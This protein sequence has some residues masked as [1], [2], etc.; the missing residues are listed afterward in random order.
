MRKIYIDTNISQI[1]GYLSGKF[2]DLLVSKLQEASILVLSNNSSDVDEIKNLINQIAGDLSKELVLLVNDSQSELAKFAKDKGFNNIFTNPITISKV[3]NKID[4]L[5]NMKNFNRRMPKVVESNKKPVK[6][7]IKDKEYKG[8]D[9]VKISSEKVKK[10]DCITI[11][12]AAKDIKATPNLDAFTP[13]LN[14]A[15]KVSETIDEYKRKIDDLEVA[16]SF[17]KD[18]CKT[19]ESVLIKLQEALSE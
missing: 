4:E 13:L 14:K 7:I 19:Y 18:K 9:Q 5:A 3:V 12:K 11:D 16:L 1:D 6:T 2:K 8:Y 17:Y 10:G 15:E